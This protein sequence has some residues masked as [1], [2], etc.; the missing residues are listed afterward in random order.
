[1]RLIRQTRRLDIAI[2]ISSITIIGIR[3]IG[4]GIVGIA[5]HP[6]AI[7]VAF[8]GNWMM[9]VAVI[10]C[11]AL[12]VLEQ[13]EIVGTVTG[14]ENPRMG[15][16]GRAR[17]SRRSRCRCQLV[18]IPGNRRH[19]CTKRRAGVDRRTAADV[20]Q[21]RRPFD[22][23]GFRRIDEIRAEQRRGTLAQTEPFHHAFRMAVVIDVIGDA[24]RV[25]S[26]WWI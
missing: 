15:I 22:A 6:R 25:F 3:R 10:G 20:L 1:M 14:I 12:M 11:V 4:I 23:G 7:L 2:I 24:A 9:I 21:T 8:G 13:M 17:H 16:A 18:V 26:D 19:R 5:R